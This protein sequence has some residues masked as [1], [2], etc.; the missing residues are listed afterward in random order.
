M[1]A[2]VTTKGEMFPIYV[3]ISFLLYVRLS[4][5]RLRHGDKSREAEPWAQ[6]SRRTHKAAQHN[7]PTGPQPHLS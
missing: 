6:N 2:C 3:F 1:Q 4:L 5:R 7:T